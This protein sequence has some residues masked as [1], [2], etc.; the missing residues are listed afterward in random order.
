MSEHLAIPV[1]Q[2]GLPISDP[3]HSLRVGQKFWILQGVVHQT[4]LVC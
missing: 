4:L 3:V 2:Q 1:D